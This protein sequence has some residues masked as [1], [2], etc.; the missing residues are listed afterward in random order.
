V[1]VVVVV[2]PGFT[3]PTDDFLTHYASHVP[4]IF[5]ISKFGI[6]VDM[7]QVTLSWLTSRSRFSLPPR[8]SLSVLDVVAGKLASRKR[9]LRE[10][11]AQPGVESTRLISEVNAERPSPHRRTR[12][13]HRD[14]PAEH[15]VQQLEDPAAMPNCKVV[16]IVDRGNSEAVCAALLVKE[17]LVPQLSMAP[18]KVPHV[19]TEHDALPPDTEC[20]L[21]LCTNGCFHS[22]LFAKQVLAAAALG[23]HFIPVVAEE[24]FHFPTEALYEEVRSRIAP[25]KLQSQKLDGTAEDLV[26]AIDTIFEEIAID[27]V[28]QGAEEI[29]AVH[30]AAIAG[31]I[32]ETRSKCV[33]KHARQDAG[34]ATLHSSESSAAPDGA[35]HLSEAQRF[36]ATLHSSESPAAP[37]GA[38]HLSEAQ[39]FSATL[40]SSESS[41]APDGSGHLSEARRFSATLHS[42]ESCAVPDGSGHLSEA[43]RFSAMLHSSESCAAPDGSGHL[44][45]AQG[46]VVDLDELW[47]TRG[48]NVGPLF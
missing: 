16:S 22:V 21:V 26:M 12:T 29:I 17:M 35:G 15:V 10:Y 27:V 8:V 37:D 11:S 42:P 30:V 25:G 48:Q 40:D 24:N 47:R 28:L 32:Q 18:E 9:G 44:S 5:G 38:G 2:L 34:A 39:R 41:A 45:E 23:V 43:R 46:F 20:A 4:G 6:S 7:A 13:L 36:S 31:R 1:D 19:L 33:L 14:H 3:W